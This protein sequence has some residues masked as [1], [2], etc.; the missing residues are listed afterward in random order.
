MLCDIC[1]QN[2]A[3]VHLTEI[4]DGQMTELHI[5][6]QCAREKSVEMEQQFG[7]SDLLAGLVDFGKQMEGKELAKM[8]CPVCKLTYEDFKKI[9]RL[10][11]SSCYSTFEHY[12][13]PL[14]KRIHG[15]ST[16]TG[17][18][19]IGV[20]RSAV[21]KPAEVKPEAARLE[22]KPEA[23]PEYKTK[24]QAEL[25]QFKQKLQNAISAENFEEAAKLRDIIRE[26]EKKAKDTQKK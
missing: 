3:T 16:H 4:V 2:N 17:K 21:P 13:I 9:G 8:Q 7:L 19:P 20:S 26:L 5:C 22:P 10:G 24:E 11:C 14:L 25:A 15:A 1:K 23:K 6:E 12:L 18:F